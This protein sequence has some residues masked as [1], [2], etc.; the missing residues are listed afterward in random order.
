MTQTITVNRLPS[1]TWNWLRVN[2][3]ALDWDDSAPLLESR[4]YTLEPGET[5]QAL[6]LSPASGEPFARREYTVTAAPGSRV[7]IFEHCTAEQ[8]FL[9]RLRLN[10]GENAD[11]RLV[12]LL[13]PQKG[14]ILR[15]EVTGDCAQGGHISLVSI[16][17]GNGDV[18]CDSQIDLRGQGASFDADYGYLGQNSRRV[19]INLNVLHRAADTRCGIT[20]G[21]ALMDRSEKVFRG[22]IDFQNGCSGSV[23]SEQETVLLLGEDVV[24]KTVPVILCAEEQVEGTHG[25]TIG[26]LDDETLFYFESRGI[27]RTQAEQ[28]LARASIERLA[29]LSEDEDFSR[30]VLELLDARLQKEEEH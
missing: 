6:R 18:Y 12:Q 13:E 24:N 8:P 4:D 10:A 29:R 26:Q 5:I 14:S 23:G 28:L 21:G 16:L 17:L 15:H 7:T 2:G 1:R 19:D 25:A 27:P 30:A 9:T 20:A 3:A 22:T 11:I